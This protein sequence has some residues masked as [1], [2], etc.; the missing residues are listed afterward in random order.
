MHSLDSIRA[1][2]THTHTQLKTFSI[3]L[4]EFKSLLFIYEYRT[5]QPFSV[6]EFVGKN[7]VSSYRA[8]SYFVS[9][10]TVLYLVAK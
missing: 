5:S 4:P 8:I 9:S 6:Y 1:K 2:Q 10:I 3:K 7:R